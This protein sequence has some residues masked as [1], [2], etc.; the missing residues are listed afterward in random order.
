MSKTPQNIATSKAGVGSSLEFSKARTTSHISSHSI[1]NNKRS[2]SNSEESVEKGN[3][4]QNQKKRSPEK[5]KPQQSRKP[6]PE[7]KEERK[8]ATEQ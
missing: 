6:A 3:S 2:V 8:K 1:N 5:E 7:K 4:P